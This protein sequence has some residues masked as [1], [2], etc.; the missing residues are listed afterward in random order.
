MDKLERVARAMAFATRCRL[1]VSEDAIEFW[2][3]TSD[4]KKREWRKAAQAAIAALEPVTVQEAARV[5]LNASGDW[6][7]VDAKVAAVKAHV[8]RDSK[9]QPVAVIEA[10]QSALRALAERGE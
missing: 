10:W 2:A 1:D 6:M 8:A 5:L 3:Y 9:T 7:P 4:D